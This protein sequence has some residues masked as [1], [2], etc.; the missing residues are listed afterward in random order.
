MLAECDAV[1][2]CIYIIKEV[3][4]QLLVLTLSASPAA[5]LPLLPPPCRSC[6]ACSPTSCC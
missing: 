1:M 3:A 2:R 6:A 5:P 4:Q